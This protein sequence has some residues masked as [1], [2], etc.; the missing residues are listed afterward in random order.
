MGLTQ[1]AA[2]EIE[3]R[4]QIAC[5]EFR[6]H[7][8]GVRSGLRPDDAAER[9]DRFGERLGRH[10]V[11]AALERARR[12]HGDAFLAGRVLRRAGADEDGDVQKR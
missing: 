10:A 3:A 7:D 6:R 12:Q 2:E 11:R 4:A 5:Q 8:G 1:H 9:L